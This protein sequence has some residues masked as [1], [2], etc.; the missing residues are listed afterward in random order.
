M[1]IFFIKLVQNGS[2][3]SILINLLYI[4]VKVSKGKAEVR[5]V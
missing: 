1:T 5:L 4:S 2:F 3:V